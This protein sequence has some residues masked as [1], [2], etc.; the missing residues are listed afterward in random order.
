MALIRVSSEMDDC[1]GRRYRLSGV[2]WNSVQ[3]FKFKMPMGF[4]LAESAKLLFIA[5]SLKTEYIAHKCYISSTFKEPGSIR[6][7]TA[8]HFSEIKLAMKFLSDFTDF[9]L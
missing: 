5:I 7:R 6:F 9:I 3:S 2:R 1:W 8:G 4:L